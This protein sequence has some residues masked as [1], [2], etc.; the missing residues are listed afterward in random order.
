ME[1]S[2]EIP[3]RNKNKTRADPWHLWVYESKK[4]TSEEKNCKCQDT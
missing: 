2:V 4:M 3:Q 1:I